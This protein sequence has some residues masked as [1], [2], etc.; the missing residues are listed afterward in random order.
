MGSNRETVT[1][2]F[3]AK[4]RVVRKSSSHG[5]LQVHFVMLIR[6][7]EGRSKSK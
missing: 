7:L 3:T 2:T 4:K 1:N 5:L 6:E